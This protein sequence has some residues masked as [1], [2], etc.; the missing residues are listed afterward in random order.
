LPIAIE[1]R[2]GDC[3]R[4]LDGNIFIDL[5]AL[6]KEPFGDAQFSTLTPNSRKNIQVHIGEPPRVDAVWFSA[7]NPVAPSACPTEP[8]SPSRDTV[9]KCELHVVVDDF[10]EMTLVQTSSRVLCYR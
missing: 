1:E 4:D 2:S 6:A 5:P 10:H 9:G 8:Y 3:A 7:V